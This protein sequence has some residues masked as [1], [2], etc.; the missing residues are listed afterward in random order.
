MA[1][2][3]PSFAL[4]KRMKDDEHRTDAE[5]ELKLQSQL[6]QFWQRITKLE[7]RVQK[8][9]ADKRTLALRVRELETHNTSLSE[10]L[11]SLKEESVSRDHLAEELAQNPALLE[12]SLRKTADHKTATESRLQ[13]LEKATAQMQNGY[14]GSPMPR[15]SLATAEAPAPGIRGDSTPHLD[16]PRHAKSSSDNANT[17]ADGSS[18][19]V[20][21]IHPSRLS[22]HFSQAQTPINT[23]GFRSYSSGIKFKGAARTSAVESP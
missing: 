10:R 4:L 5:N 1:T 19:N 6:D 11:F 12:R 7:E 16:T 23:G 22:K 14:S 9:E 20:G 18:S 21:H 13:E 2:L 8:S 15:E 3:E 17:T